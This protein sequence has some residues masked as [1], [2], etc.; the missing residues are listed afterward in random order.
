MAEIEGARRTLFVLEF[1]GRAHLVTVKKLAEQPGWN[2][3][4]ACRYLRDIC[5]AGWLERVNETGDPKYILGPK[6]LNLTPEMRF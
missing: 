3:A 6:A 4:S 2:P 1:T 5:D